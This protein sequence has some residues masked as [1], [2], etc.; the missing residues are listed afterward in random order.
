[1]RYRIAGEGWSEEMRVRHDTLGREFEVIDAEGARHRVI[2]DVLEGKDVL[3]ITVGGSSHVLS[4]LPGNRPGQALRFLVDD[5]YHELLVQDEIDLLQEVLGGAGGAGGE[6]RVESVMPG[7]IR[8]LLVKS[9]SRVEAGH[10]LLILE[11]MKMENEVRAPVAGRV[12]RVVVSEGS[13]VGSGE[14]LLVIAAE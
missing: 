10:A 8:K 11:A 4:V 2:V 12:E 6:V 5:E 7:V 1:M 9:G 14:L 3:R 13:A